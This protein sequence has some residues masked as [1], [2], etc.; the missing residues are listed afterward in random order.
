MRRLK[1]V[2]AYDG[3]N[4]RGWQRQPARRTVQGVMEEHLSAVLKEPVRLT[5]AGRT[6][7]GCH[8]RGQV[9]SLATTSRLPVAAMAPVLN[10]RLPSDVR[11]REVTEAGPD[12]DARRSAIARRYAYRLLRTEDLLL[13]RIAWHPPRR[14]DPEAL[15]RATAPLEGV[16]DFAS[17]RSTG[18]SA[19]VS[20]CHVTRA[21]WRPWEGGILLDIVAD[22]FLY[23]MVRS[24]VGTALVFQSDSD[25]GARMRECLDG[26]DR[27]LAGPTAPAHG[28]C[29]EEVFY[30]DGAPA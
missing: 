12:F 2:V 26:R 29:L 16:Q 14:F 6:D 22:H 13:S 4:F 18:S 27:G 23:H 9:A 11:V 28:L 30:P 24:I 1:L 3:A 10:R 20:V 19:A 5:G 8:A 7:T 15:A 25:P 21:A 17:F